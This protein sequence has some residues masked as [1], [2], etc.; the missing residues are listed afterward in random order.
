MFAAKIER[1]SRDHHDRCFAAQCSPQ[2]TRKKPSCTQ[3]TLGSEAPTK[4]YKNAGR[5]ERYPGVPETILAR[6]PV[7]V[8][9]RLRRSWLRPTAED[10]SAFGQHRKFPPHA[11]KTSATQGTR[12]LAFCANK[13]RENARRGISRL[14]GIFHVFKFNQSAVTTSLPF[15]HAT[16]N[17]SLLI[18]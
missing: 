11:R 10:V 3:G 8:K 1:Q 16:L 13:R 5:R 2:T 7:S 17:D 18:L 15:S 12:T 4:K 6:F 14:T 9:S